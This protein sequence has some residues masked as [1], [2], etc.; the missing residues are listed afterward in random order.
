[1]ILAKEFNEKRKA[2]F[3]DGACDGQ[4]LVGWLSVNPYCAYHSGP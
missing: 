2:P 3:V 4:H 1:M